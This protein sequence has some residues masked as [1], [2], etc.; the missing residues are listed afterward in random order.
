MTIKGGKEGAWEYK[1][2][3]LG[4]KTPKGWVIVAIG[5]THQTI[6]YTHWERVH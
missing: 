4:A 3:P 5:A 2:Q 1:T 6:K